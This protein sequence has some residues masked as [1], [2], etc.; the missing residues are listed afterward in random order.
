VTAAEVEAMA[1]MAYL[2]HG[3]FT[4]PWEVVPSAEQERWRAV[5]RAVVE[6]AL[7]RRSSP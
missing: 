5:V 6:R 4:L 3:A 2:A 7:L 1:K